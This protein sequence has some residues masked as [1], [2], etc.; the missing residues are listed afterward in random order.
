MNFVLKVNLSSNFQLKC[1][2]AKN[3]KDWFET[4]WAGGRLEVPASCCIDLKQCHNL[5]PV[6]VD[7]IYKEVIFL[8]TQY[9]FKEIIFKNTD[10]KN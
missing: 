7:D 1:C 2:G 6:M 10:R 9:I 8:C 4:T 5:E 3:Y